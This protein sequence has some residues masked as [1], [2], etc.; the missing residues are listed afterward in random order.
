MCIVGGLLYYRT[1]EN[2]VW[3]ENSRRSM[4]CAVDVTV[5]SNH[6]NSILDRSDMVIASFDSGTISYLSMNDREMRENTE[7]EET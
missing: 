7:N 3:Q 2:M 4:P 6:S 5:V 1:V